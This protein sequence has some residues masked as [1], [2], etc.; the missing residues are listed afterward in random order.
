MDKSLV[1]VESPA[2]ARTIN[3]FLGKDFVVIAS[4]GHIKDL[5]KNKLSVDI[6]NGFMPH[7][8]IIKGKR[9]T[10]AELKK[11][12][13]KAKRIYLAP[14][15]DREGEAIAWHIAEEM[16][17]KKTEVFRVL[18]NEITE[19]A[20]KEAIA[21]PIALDKNKFEAHKARRVLDRL[22]GYQVSPLLWE[23]VKWGLSAGRVQ[24]VAVRL[25]CEREREI[26]AFIPREYWSITAEFTDPSFNARLAWKDGKKIEIPSNNEAEKIL[27]DLK[28]AEFAVTDVE[29]KEKRRQPSAPFT[30]S[31][32]Q[33]EASRKLGFTAKKTMAVAQQLYEGIDI[34]K[35][36]PVGLITYMRT[37]SVRLSSEAISDAREFIG[38][39][40]GNEFLPEK[41]NA[42]KS[43][44]IAQEAHEAIRPTYVGLL[45]ESIKDSLTRDQLRLYE[46]IWKRFVA[47]Q[48]SPMVLDQTRVLLDA[49]AYGFSA[50]G[51]TV[52]FA[53]F[54]Q[55]Y[56][57]GK[58]QIEEDD[59]EGTLPLISKGMRLAASAIEPRQHFTEPLPR[60]SEATLVKELEENGIGRPSTYAAILSTIQDRGYVVRENKQFAP[61]EVGF[62]V[63]ELLTESFPDLF[64]IKF[65]ARMEE[66]LDLIEEGRH[67]WIEIMQE[68]YTPFKQS[69]D[70]A[71]A[72]MRNLKKE[73]VKTDLECEKC[74]K[75]MNIRW[76]KNGR[77]LAC[78]GYPECKNTKD[79]TIDAQGRVSPV[80]RQEEI[81][82]K[83]PTCSKPMVVKSGRFGRF[84]ACSAYPECKTTASFSTGVSCKE[85][86]CGGVLVEKRAKGGRT[87]YGC[88]NYP[89]CRY[90]VW[91]LPS[92]GHKG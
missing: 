25:I 20:V 59:E 11:A 3:K 75:P 27:R 5:P 9:K 2:K 79:F 76:G 67:G 28:G 50:T 35:E 40:F 87:F 91:K 62:T 48:M 18:F 54:S 30:T 8:E 55:V 57:E 58:D 43:K 88:S 45:P 82:G 85:E 66:E 68:F 90:A 7:Y 78:S 19:R 36:G 77:F 42:Y 41:P 65:T 72:G 89:K 21:H 60:F 16:D 10:I 81:K 71:S 6:A 39:R 70:K 52:R 31:K 69:L 47:C 26:R 1:I 32:L 4:V 49:G 15:P 84:L 29:K 23:R 53:G 38:K 80:E 56:V 44:K 73:E 63:T 33:Q 74:S 17:G 61:T 92:T 13:K 34:G 14:D 51:S 12:T 86:G 83:C 24:S 22:V 46:L 64:N 37:D